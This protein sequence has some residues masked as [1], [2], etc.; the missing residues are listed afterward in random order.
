MQAH[1]ATG[2]RLS[3]AALRHRLDLEQALAGLSRHFI[4]DEID[5]DHVLA[6][7]GRTVGVHRAYLFRLRQDGRT[8]DNTH[9][10]CAPGTRPEID[11]LQG[12][13]A[14]AFPWWMQR[15]RRGEV[16]S[17]ADVAALPQE[18]HAEREI[19]EAQH[20]RAVLVVP[21]RLQNGALYGFVGFDDTARARA[22][23]PEDLH[24]L[25]VVSDLMTTYLARRETEEALRRSEERWRRLIQRSPDAILVQMEGQIV[26]LNDAACQLLGAA[27]DDEVFTRPLSAFV[28][29]AHH[30]RLARHLAG[31]L[32]D[33]ADLVYPLRTLD[34]NLRYVEVFAEPMTYEGRRAQEVVLHDVTQHKL[35]EERLIASKEEAEEMSRL[36]SAFLASMSHDIRTPLT[37]IIGFADLLAREVEGSAQE[38]ARLIQKS[39]RRLMEILNAVLDLA[40]LDSRAKALNLVPTDLAAQA[41]EVVAMFHPQ[42]AQQG[43]TLRLETKGEQAVVALVDPTGFGRV[44]LNLISNA[45]KFTPE[46]SVTVA[47]YAEGEQAVVAVEDTGIGIGPAF[48]EHLFDEFRQEET[49]LLRS[50]H[51]S[52]LGLAIARRLVEEMGGEIA[53]Q[54]EPGKG[55]VFTVRFPRYAHHTAEDDLRAA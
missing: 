22:W 24:V 12:L 25:R 11:N 30:E 10:W 29:P 28:L 52:G 39:G 2:R 34:D 20:I 4:A 3:E 48:M 33:D 35:H 38:F 7:L 17:V 44:L 8:L 41:Y 18:A 31:A 19:L 43:L 40:Q 36:K 49:G 42:A 50:R 13:D 47:V 6:V 27:S 1:D 32:P 9:E 5:L 55:S 23:L 37:S 21:I 54:S 53:V 16:I 51:G 15:L 26:Y 45:L 46:G 14:A